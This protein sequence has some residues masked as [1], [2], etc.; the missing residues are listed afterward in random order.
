MLR[1][2]LAS[3]A[4]VI[5]SLSIYSAAL[6]QGNNLWPQ[7]SVTL[8]LSILL[9]ATLAAVF[10][11]NSSRVFAIGF[12]IV[13]WL[14]FTIVFSGF[15]GGVRENLLT[16]TA[17]NWL[18]SQVH[19]PG[20]AASIQVA[21][22]SPP[23]YPQAGVVTRYVPVPSTSSTPLAVTEYALQPATSLSV[24]QQTIALAAAPVTPTRIL[25]NPYHFAQIGHSLWV[26]L[27]GAMGGVVAQVIYSRSSRQP[28]SDE[29]S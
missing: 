22:P 8:T 24:V 27:I 29:S 20:A 9:L 16:Q 12:S 3:L 13:G 17:I 19:A 18:Y 1:Y 25:V 7:I 23:G 10:S 15:A 5:V 14:Y 28:N 2:S 26:V 4:I 6:A 11:R 21:Y